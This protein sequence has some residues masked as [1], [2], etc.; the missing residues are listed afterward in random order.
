L[1]SAQRWL[2]LVCLLLVAVCV[3]I[4]STTDLFAFARQ[5]WFSRQLT[6]LSHQSGD[7]RIVIAGID[8]ASSVPSVFNRHV[9][10]QVIRNLA[11]A[12]ARLIFY[13]VEFDEPRGPVD[14]DLA[15][16]VGQADRCVLGAAFK[17]TDKG[18]EKP[19]L[20]PDFTPFLDQDRAQLGVINKDSDAMLQQTLLAVRVH[21]D[22]FLSAAGAML[23]MLSHVRAGD[24]KIENRRVSIPPYLPPVTLSQQKVGD[25]LVES[26]RFSVVYGPPATGPDASQRPG[27]YRVIPYRE[28]VQSD[29]AVLRSLS[30]CVVCVGDNTS[31]ETDLVTTPVGRIKGVEVHARALDTLLHGPLVRQSLPGTSLYLEDCL[32]QLAICLLLALVLWSQRSAARMIGCGLAAAC[33]SAV[34]YGALGQMGWLMNLPLLWL[35]IGLI[36]SACAL[37]R[38]AGSSS[39]LASF[40]PRE[41]ARQ[42]LSTGK[43]AVSRQ[44]ATVI[45]TDIR[46]YT[47]LSETK[48]P[49]QILTMLNEYHTETVS[50]FERFG[51]S[52]LNYQGDAQII[53]FG[54]PRRLKD[55][56]RQAILAAIETSYA[57]ER[58]RVRWGLSAE[59]TFEV[60]AGVCTGL[61]WVGEL[62]SASAQAEFT[63]IGE[64]VRRCHKVQSLSNKLSSNVLADE[65]T[66]RA[67]AR[68]AG[69]ADLG[70][71]ELDGLAQPVRLFGL[72]P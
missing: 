3:R 32:L 71:V 29:S 56:A 35:E 18:Y 14:K 24:V 37:Q 69:L 42:L 12:K 55:A 34:L 13:D 6:W 49:R 9:H 48:T 66:I 54:Y 53:L 41:V 21:D 39:A 5:A 23:A 15:A 2:L 62:G 22:V 65:A 27:T 43:E 46:G 8:D 10:A 17:V 72:R 50:I 36:F 7:P 19:T 67:C 57:I 20:I 31:G 60:G 40:I 45:V 63:V 4:D 28:L 26:F 1:V 38:Y 68:S 30:G 64:T 70:E 59:Q 11:R 33:S 47:S 61:V 44:V 52:V 25:S 16:A 51:G 58:L